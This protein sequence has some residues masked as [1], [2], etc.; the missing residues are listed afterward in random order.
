MDIAC[1]EWHGAR[2]DGYGV[3]SVH[4]RNVR[5]HRIVLGCVLMR[6]F[7]RPLRDD[8]KALHRCD[9]PPCWRPDHLFVGTLRDNS[10]DMAAKGRQ[11]F[12]AHPERAPSGERNG[13]VVLT[14]AQVSEL[15]ERSAGGEPYSALVRSF[16]I[17]KTQVSRL[18]RAQ[19]RR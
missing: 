15:R 3:V 4:G 8:E 14:D 6:V 2:S 13:R 16:G 11:V 17:S 1:W 5:V 9:N 7:G 18:V 12:Q 10:R 19:Q